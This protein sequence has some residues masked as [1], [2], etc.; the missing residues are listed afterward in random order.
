MAPALAPSPSRRTSSGPRPLTPRHRRY[1]QFRGRTLR[2]LDREIDF[3]ANPC[4]HLPDEEE[5]IL[6]E[7]PE[8]SDRGTPSQPPRDLPAHLARLCEMQLLNAEQETFLFR[9]MNYLKFRANALRSRLDPERPEPKLIERIESLLAEADE[10]RDHILQANMRLVISVVKKFVVPQYSF[11]EI[12]SDGIASLIQAVEK[13]DYDR[14]FR[15]STYAY[16]AIARNAFRQVTQRQKEL[17]RAC[18]I[19]TENGLDVPDEHSGAKLSFSSWQ[20]LRDS[21]AGLLQHLDRRERFILEGR[22]A[23]GDAAKVRTFQSLADE[24]GVSKE[25]VRQLEQRA[26]GKLR[27]MSGEAQLERFTDCLDWAE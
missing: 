7:Q 15:F 17:S 4:F 6:N 26:V 13:F 18:T 3:V 2:L 11:D 21:L 20:E 23:L 27:K 5:E 9:K 14:G 1:E 22:F 16:R 19:S 24:L 8:T 25:R 12:L 10:I